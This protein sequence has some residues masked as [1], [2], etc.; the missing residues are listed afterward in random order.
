MFGFFVVSWM[1]LYLAFGAC[2]FE[3]H[4]DTWERLGKITQWTNTFLRQ[5]VQTPTT[6]DL[7]ER[8]Y[9]PSVVFLG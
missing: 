4:Y 7:V 3:F 2:F 8:F 9:L 1:V 5:V 6:S